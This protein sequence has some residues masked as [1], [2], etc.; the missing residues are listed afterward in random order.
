MKGDHMKITVT[1]ELPEMQYK[2]L[3]KYGYD[4]EK[5]AES[6]AYEVA[7][8]LIWCSENPDIDS[9]QEEE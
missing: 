9:D 1:Y 5:N 4:F 3:K 6:Q 7:Q 8:T 2:I